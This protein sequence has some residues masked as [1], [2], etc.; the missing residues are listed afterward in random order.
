M[1][2][3]ALSSAG[4]WPCGEYLPMGCYENTGANI[5]FTWQIETAAAWGWECSDSAGELYLQTY[6]PSFQESGFLKTLRPGEVFQS[7][8][9]AIASV[10]G[11]FEETIRALTKYRRIIRRKNND[12]TN[13]A[14]LFNDYMNCLMGDPSTEKEIPLI[15]AAADAGCKYYCIDCGWYDDGPWWDGVGQWLPSKARFPHGIR[16]VLDHIRARGMIPGLWLELEVMGIECPLAKKVLGGWFFQREGRPI[17][18]HGRY[19]LDFR[20][21]EVSAF[22]DTVIDRL[23]K[24]YHVGYIKMDYNINAGAGTDRNSSSA[25]AGLLEHTRAYLEWID[26]VFIRYPELV[27]ENCGSGGM[28]ME[29]SLLSRFSI[30]SVTD[31]TDYLR[32]AAIACNCMSAVTPEQA[33]IW[34]YPLASG[35]V[36]ETI[37]N[38]VNAILFRIHQSGHLANLE[39]D[40]MNYVREGIAYHKRIA[41]RLKDGL[42]FWPLGLAS[43]S[44]TFLCAG[45]DCGS[46]RYLA[47]WCISEPGGT[48][49][50]PL[51]TDSDKKYHF[52]CAYPEAFS[53]P[54]H[55]EPEQ[56]LLSVSIKGKTAR[57]VEI[58]TE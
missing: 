17:I 16:E 1:K 33:A 21:T 35:D 48:F 15:E 27:I 28:R 13:P 54:L 58:T 32:M 5:A 50:L 12:N 22:A 14:V 44:D 42:P 43:M 34:S 20:N 37:F 55:W 8:P 45:I 51:R 38:M 9:C 11:G 31:Q 40:R 46:I 56:S 26:R 7:V 53:I 3:I 57:I 39:E 6:G 23:V 36:E 19:Q 10:K 47:L 52:T 4:S 29:Y 49:T 30:Q 18:D 2:R 41:P 24:E 25:A